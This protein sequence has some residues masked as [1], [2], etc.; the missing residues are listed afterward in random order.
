M[1]IISYA[2]ASMS[3]ALFVTGLAVLLG[4]KKD[5]NAKRSRNSIFG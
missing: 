5:K 3:G 2:L 1:T 4:G